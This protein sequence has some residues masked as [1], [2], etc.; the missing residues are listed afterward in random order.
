MNP[1]TYIGATNMAQLT[2]ELHRAKINEK[3]LM[4]QN[5][6]HKMK[7]SALIKVE[8]SLKKEQHEVAMLRNKA[9][10]QDLHVDQLRKD[11]EKTKASLKH[12]ETQRA[13]EKN[14]SEQRIIS[15]E[16]E[17]LELQNKFCVEKM[18]R[19]QKEKELENFSNMRGENRKLTM[20]GQT[21]HHQVQELTGFKNYAT[22]RIEEQSQLLKK[23]DIDHDETKQ[24]LE[25]IKN[26]LK[27]NT[28]EVDKLA[29]V[30]DR[31]ETVQRQAAQHVNELKKH[32]RQADTWKKTIHH[33]KKETVTLTRQNME[34]SA[35]N[36]ELEQQMDQL[37]QDKISLAVKIQN[38][39]KEA[40]RQSN[41]MLNLENE[42]NSFSNLKTKLQNKEKEI[43]RHTMS[44]DR[45]IVN[46]RNLI[47]ESESMQRMQIIQTEAVK[48]ERNLIAENL[49]KAES[50]LIRM[51]E[52]VQQ[53]NADIRDKTCE[54]HAK[55]AEVVK[56]NREYR[57][58][59]NRLEKVKGQLAETKMTQK[60]CLDTA[61]QDQK[62][63]E[64]NLARVGAER[65]KLDKGLARYKELVVLQQQKIECQKADKV[66]QEHSLKELTEKVNSLKIEL[67]T[68]EHD[69]YILDMAMMR[70]MTKA[71]TQKPR[72]E[73]IRGRRKNPPLCL[74]M[75]YNEYQLFGSDAKVD[76]RDKE[77]EELKRKL[78]RRPDDAIRKLQLCQWTN[79]DLKEQLR[80]SKGLL[81]AY[82]TKYKSENEENKRLTNEL[83]KLKL[84]SRAKS[85]N[86]CFAPI[87]KSQP[88]S[89]DK[90]KDQREPSHVSR[91]TRFPLT[92]SQ[93]QSEDK[94]QIAPTPPLFNVNVNIQ[95][96][97]R[98]IRP[99]P[100][101]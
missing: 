89:E 38:H 10:S 83:R 69:Y 34:L 78:N 59:R 32:M 6:Q 100:P 90:S 79:R 88:P 33:L 17:R 101:P 51:N 1:N 4:D 31:L 41:L 60:I 76:E 9:R 43:T 39:I 63:A 13:H 92:K 91:H 42:L 72:R 58:V 28:D 8:M 64:D 98:K 47:S 23:K 30:Q 29:P 55:D 67:T 40:E 53:L 54:I 56:I 82:E 27:Q 94:S 85:R 50:E 77:I 96:F 15:L 46:L 25:R 18:F 20:N 68:L 95:C 61:N 93:H 70:E 84:E 80:A 21:L 11:L 87:S 49:F 44:R 74:Q 14:V 71:K 24:E 2:S 97:G 7:L 5:K 26:Q 22:K 12:E 66:I 48:T 57:S 99:H 36:R 86:T 16:K 75:I 19:E 35:V 52:K 45:E 65:E 37:Q 81:T 62:L 3:R 73:R